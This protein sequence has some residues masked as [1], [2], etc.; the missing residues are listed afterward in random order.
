MAAIIAAWATR[1]PADEVRTG[2][3]ER[4]FRDEHGTHKYIVFVPAG[5][6]P[7]KKWPVI[8]YLHGASARGTD[9]QVP[10]V[11]GL[12]AQIRARSESF[13]FLVVFPQCEEQDPRVFS[14]WGSDSADGA[15]ALKILDAVESEFNVDRSRESL[16]GWSM[17]GYGAWNLAASCPERWSAVVIVAGEVDLAKAANL[18]NV[19]VWSFHGLADYGVPIDRARQMI[20]AIRQAGGSPYLTELPNVGHNL[21]HVVY[22]ED[23]LYAWLLNPQETPQPENFIRHASR[24]P[25]K[26][27]MGRDFE[28][29]FVPAVEIPNAFY[30]RLDNSVLESIGYAIPPMVPEAALAGATP[31]VH[32]T[33][34]GFMT[35]FDVE[36]SGL[37]YRGQ[38]EQVRVTTQR[39]GW[40][41]LQLGL[42]NLTF[43]VAQTSVT[44]V[45]TSATAG[46]MDIVVGNREPIWI[47]AQV[48]P[49]V[50]EHHLRLE[51]GEMNVQ[52]QDDNWYVT[53]P[54][55][56]GSGLPFLRSRVADSVS[57][58]MV[59]DA[60]GRKHE[61]E[62]QIK[63]AVPQLLA[64]M[65]T[66]LEEVFATPR[67]VG[68]KLPGPTY[69]PRCILWPETIKVDETGLAMTLGIALSRPG[70][71]PPKLPVHRITGPPVDFDQFPKVAGLQLAVAGTVC[72]A[73]TEACSNSAM[74]TAD[75]R[76][77]GVRKFSQLSDRATMT[78]IIPDL[79]RYGDQLRIRAH[80]EMAAPVSFRGA[81]SA[82]TAEGAPAAIQSALMQLNVSNLR[83]VVQI[84][85]SP[86]QQSW[87]RCAEF[88]M[89]MDYLARMS[90]GKPT[91]ERRM[92]VTDMLTDP[93]VKVTARFAA[94]YEANDPTLRG[95]QVGK[96]FASGWHDEGPTQFLHGLCRESRAKDLEFGSARVRLAAITWRDP[97]IFLEYSLP[98][99]RITN[100]TDRPVEYQ[101]RGPLSDW[102]GPYVLPPEKSHDFPVPYPVTFR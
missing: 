19:R 50:E 79:A 60:Y 94:G 69:L 6:T 46:P 101:I 52:I 73:M 63:G 22:S 18:K 20:E 30:V 17:G 10:I 24:A 89:Q 36:L 21:G 84:K 28:F 15:R 12:G 1:L 35:Q 9:N 62:S 58:K 57:R 102:G 88:D 65:E 14:G 44:G 41:T 72:E 16:T 93:N 81:P 100:T 55:V 31:N 37:T 43:Q 66:K 92:V 29:P 51:L 4:I 25:T 96:I 23:A 99:T 7:E 98:R 42:R 45:L 56:V 95:E 86:D 32:Q 87:Q 78:E 54:S 67:I 90:V 49:S 91:F 53:T 61:I 27:E 59:S 97:Y 11:G 47:T 5:Y 34:R 8:L 13:P 75:V 82:A 68:S 26:A 71:N 33:S 64:K 2:F 77:L 38:L 39:N 76:E 74:T 83:T 70:L 48:R 80:F 40:A 3:Q 85:T